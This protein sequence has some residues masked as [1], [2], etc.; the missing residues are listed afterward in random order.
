MKPHANCATSEIVS[1]IVRRSVGEE[2]ETNLN[3]NGNSVSSR[4]FAVRGE[5]DDD[6]G[7]HDT[8]SDAELV[9]RY[10][11]STDLAR[12][13]FRHVCKRRIARRSQ[14]TCGLLES[15]RRA[16]SVTYRG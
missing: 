13:D 12:A 2:E 8:D 9:T 1:I 10:E 5:V 3:S 14:F 15:F 16:G 11:R 7:K 4:V 6:G